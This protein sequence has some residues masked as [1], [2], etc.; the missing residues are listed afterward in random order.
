MV[1]VALNR[2]FF[3]LITDIVCNSSFVF[4]PWVMSMFET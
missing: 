3:S 2:Y 4:G 1:L